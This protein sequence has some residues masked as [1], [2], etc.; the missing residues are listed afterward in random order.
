MRLEKDGQ[1]IELTQRAHIE[2][3]LHSGW[4]KATEQ[5]DEEQKKTKR[6]KAQAEE[7]PAP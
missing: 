1:T 5:D 6:R 3:Y 2:A 4:R 7:S